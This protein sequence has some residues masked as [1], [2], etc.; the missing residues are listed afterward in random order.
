MKLT[1]LLQLVN[2]LLTSCNKPVKLTICNK[3]VVFWAVYTEHSHINPMSKAFASLDHN[4]SDA[5]CQ[6]AW[7]KLMANL[8]QV[9]NIHNLDQVCSFSGCVSSAL[10]RYWHMAY[11]TGGG[12]GGGGGGGFE[13][14][15]GQKAFE[16]IVYYMPLILTPPPTWWTFVKEISLKL[17]AQCAS[18]RECSFALLLLKQG[19][20]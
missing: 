3:S 9:V 6:Q 2:N 8:H 7:C 17:R 12:G 19:R 5:N 4:K 20:N 1:S 10:R 13:K 11:L 16:N 18:L 14:T 15:A